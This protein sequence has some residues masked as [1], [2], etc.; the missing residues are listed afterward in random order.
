VQELGKFTVPSAVRPGSLPWAETN[1]KN[2]AQSNTPTTIMKANRLLL[3]IASTPTL[4]RLKNPV[5]SW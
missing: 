3:S 2:P 1:K 4:L 5:E